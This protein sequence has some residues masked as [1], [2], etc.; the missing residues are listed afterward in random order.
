MNNKLP[1][2]NLLRAFEAAGQHLSFKM[3]AEQLFVTP[4]AISQ[5]IHTL[6]AQLGFTLFVRGNRSL[7]MTEIG[8][9]YW[10]R[11]HHHLNGIREATAELQRQ[12]ATE[13]LR[14]SIMPPVSKRVVVPKLD[15]FHRDYPEIELHID[16]S[17]SNINLGSGLA[18]LAIRFGTP[19]WEGLIHERLIDVY[20]QIL[21]PPGFTERYQLE[22]NI[23]N[24]LKMPLVQMTSRPTAWWDLWFSQTGLGNPSGKQFYVDD[25]PAAIEASETLGAALGLAPIEASLIS[26]GRVESPFPPI[27]PMDEA[28]YAVYPLAQKNNPSVRAFID[29]LREQLHALDQADSPSS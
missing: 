21:C 6:E 26:S 14:V 1:S 25:Y 16:A 19:P 22:G 9:N 8:R 10:A 4:S 17:P 3:A 13:V 28:I 12:H 11:I 18:D 23:G 27:G 29:W 7:K 2:L 20:I 24:V 5:Q 15:N